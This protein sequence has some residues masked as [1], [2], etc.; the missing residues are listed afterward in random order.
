MIQ[1]FERTEN[2]RAAFKALKSM[3]LG[4]DQE[5]LMQKR[6]EDWL[7]KAMFEGRKKS[8]S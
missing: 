3:Y 5:T 7:H 8:M 6:S 2:G 4:L 1:G